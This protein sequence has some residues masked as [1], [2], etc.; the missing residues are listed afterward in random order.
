MKWRASLLVMARMRAGIERQR[1]GERIILW[2]VYPG[3]RPLR[4][5]TPGYYLSPL[6]APTGLVDRL[7]LV[8]DKDA[9][10][11]ALRIRFGKL[12]RGGSEEN[13][14]RPRVS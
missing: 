13:L 5:L 10:P 4:V 12:Y 6:Q 14:H 7:G 2:D 8:F 9:A 1:R 3:L 11:T